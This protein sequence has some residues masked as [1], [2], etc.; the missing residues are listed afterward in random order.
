[1]VLGFLR[2]VLFVLGAALVC[3]STETHECGAA[4]ITPP[5]LVRRD[6]PIGSRTDF[7]GYQFGFDNTCEY[8]AW[9]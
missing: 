8:P 5:P 1:M 9:M 4:V 7:V 6:D 3:S 2:L